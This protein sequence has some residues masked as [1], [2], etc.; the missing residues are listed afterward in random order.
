MDLLFV[1]IEDGL[2]DFV[3]NSITLKFPD[4]LWWYAIV[5]FVGGKYCVGLSGHEEVV[6]GKEILRNIYEVP[7]T[8]ELSFP[9]ERWQ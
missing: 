3:T 6:V 5:V 2:L 7:S 8:G 1:H 9:R 4:P